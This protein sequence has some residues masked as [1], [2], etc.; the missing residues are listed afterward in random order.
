[1]RMSSTGE[2]KPAAERP[3]DALITKGLVR[4]VAERY[5]VAEGEVSPEWSLFFELR[6]GTGHGSQ[7]SYVDAFALNL[8]ASKKYWRVA[9]EFKASR[10]DFLRELKKPSK[11]SWGMEVSNEF[12][13]ICYPG[14]AKPEEIPAGCGLMVC[15]EKLTKLRK[16]VQAPQRDARPLNMSEVSAL[17]R[18]NQVQQQPLFRYSGKD[19]T[20][21]DLDMLLTQRQPSFWRR[22]LG[23]EAS[24]QVEAGLERAKSVLQHYA[25]SLRE[26]GVEPPAWMDAPDLTREI[27]WNARGWATEQLRDRTDRLSLKS[28][29]ESLTRALR[30]LERGLEHLQEAHTSA[31]ALLAPPKQPGPTQAPDSEAEESS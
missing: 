7:T 18:R 11:R 26:A 12:W 14:V 9:M 15:D 8:W 29:A 17:A 10:Q 4:L 20:E 24:G 5:A 28:Q 13:Y 6:S 27:P 25:R 30:Q 21:T 3:S 19:L 31:Q 23:K 2:S 16:V 1:M 22:E